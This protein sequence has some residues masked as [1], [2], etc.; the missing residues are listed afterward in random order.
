MMQA[1][2]PPAASSTSW[3]DEPAPAAP[4]YSA[5][6]APAYSPPRAQAARSPSPIRGAGDRRRAMMQQMTAPAGGAAPAPSYTPPPAPAV[7]FHP[8]SP[9]THAFVCMQAASSAESG[10]AKHISIVR[11]SVCSLD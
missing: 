9:C 8:S 6:A 2:T 5:P 10:Q 11:R 3:Y 4:A 7:R 1:Y